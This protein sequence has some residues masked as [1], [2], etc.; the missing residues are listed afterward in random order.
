MRVEGLRLR[1]RQDRVCGLEFRGLGARS[2]RVWNSLGSGVRETGENRD[3]RVR[4]WV[5]VKGLDSG[6]RPAG[7]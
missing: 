4:G 1:V 3:L 6:L 5:L 2:L 7:F